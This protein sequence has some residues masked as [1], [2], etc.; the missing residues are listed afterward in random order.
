MRRTVKGHLLASQDLLVESLYNLAPLLD[1][2]LACGL[3]SQ[4]NYYE[5]K[6]ETT[7]PNRARKLLEVLHAQM[8]EGGASCFLECLRRCKQ[9]Y[10]RLRS[11]LSQDAGTPH[12]TRCY[13]AQVCPLLGDQKCI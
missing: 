10:P 8:D 5:V 11:W 1:R 12:V 4:D 3:L 7:P 2:L 9:H 13:T 6:A